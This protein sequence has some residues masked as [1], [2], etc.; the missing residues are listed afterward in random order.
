MTDNLQSE[1]QEL[2][3]ELRRLERIHNPDEK[4]LHFDFPEKADEN[5]F[6]KLLVLAQEGLAMVRKHRDFF[7]NNALYADGMF[8]YD[9]FLL[10][11]SAS[12]K[13]KTD[14]NQQN[15]PKD[16]IFD[17]AIV[18]V[19]I[20]EYSAPRGGDITKR[21]HEALGNTLYCFYS[22]DLV[23]SIRKRS[24]ESR[25]QKTMEFV[26]WTISKVEALRQ[27]DNKSG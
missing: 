23:E 1:F 26:E 10:I 11:S 5:L 2:H 19:D 22:Q 4:N 24:N 13:I 12:M 6:S 14:M 17:L 20:V 8:W 15:T 25:N 9:L 16:I 27:E 18:L 3:S 7:L 21:N